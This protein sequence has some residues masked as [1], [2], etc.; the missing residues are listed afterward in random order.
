M[1]RR[2]IIEGMSCEKCAQR[3]EKALQ[4]L[5]ENIR[6]SVN[7]KKKTAVLSSKNE[8]VDALIRNAVTAAGYE[9]TDIL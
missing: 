5:D 7:L 2:V 4:G 6:V 3:V 9:V 8:I 1:K